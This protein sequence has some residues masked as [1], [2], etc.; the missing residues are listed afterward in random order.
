MR[1]RYPIAAVVAALAAGAVAV[2]TVA[3]SASAGLRG[4]IA[5]GSFRSQA[6]RGTEHYAVYL[7]PDYATA[8]KRYPV[9]YFLHGLPASST[10]Y[11]SIEVI[12]RAVERS[13]REAIVVGVQ[14]ARAGDMDP[15]WRNWGSGRNWETATAVELVRAIDHR[16]QSRG[17]AGCCAWPH[18]LEPFS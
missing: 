4:T 8:S 14:G 2:A 7:P 3:H 5:Y 17:S 1:C 13:G 18:S 12:A 6:L 9:L 15:E 16:L 11:R 10:A